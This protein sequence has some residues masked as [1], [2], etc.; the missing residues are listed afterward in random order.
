[1]RLYKKDFQSEFEVSIVEIDAEKA[2]S[3]LTSC[4]I[5]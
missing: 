4:R 5:N 1:M 2:F 3:T